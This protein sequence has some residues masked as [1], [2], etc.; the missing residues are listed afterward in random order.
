MTGAVIPINH[1][2]REPGS[3]HYR[4]VGT[5]ITVEF[6]SYFIDDPNWRMEDICAQFDLTPGEVYAA[7][8]FYYD[9]KA[10]IDEHLQGDRLEAEA[11]FAAH[12]DIDRRREHLIQQWEAETGKKFDDLT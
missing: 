4:I 1:I 11:Y 10:E 5:R 6:L 2:E 9:H 3:H 7:W 12:P 8:A